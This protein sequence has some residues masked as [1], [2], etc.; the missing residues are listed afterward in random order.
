MIENYLRSDDGKTKPLSQ[1]PG[2]LEAA[3]HVGGMNNGLFGYQ[4]QRETAR[5]L[6][7]ALKN[8]PAVGATA[9]NPLSAMPFSSAGNGSAGLLMDF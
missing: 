1:K 3:Q 2:L 9:L 6:F 8:D 4:N 5:A 7:A